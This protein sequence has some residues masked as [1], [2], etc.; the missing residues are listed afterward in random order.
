[1]HAHVHKQKHT[2]ICVD[3]CKH[4]DTLPQALMHEHTYTRT[5]KH[6]RT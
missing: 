1:M 5:Y 2:R 3:T 4:T 6:V